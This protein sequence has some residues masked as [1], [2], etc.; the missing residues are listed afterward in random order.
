VGD[1]PP[2]SSSSS[3]S[4]LDMVMPMVL[5]KVPVNRGLHS[6]PFQ[7]NLSCI[8]SPYPHMT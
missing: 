1:A 4:S 8:G 7:L 6:W 2:A 5:Q 3:S